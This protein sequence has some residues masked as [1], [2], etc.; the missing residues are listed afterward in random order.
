MKHA[1]ASVPCA[2]KNLPNRWKTVLDCCPL[3]EMMF[4]PQGGSLHIFGAGAAFNNRGQKATVLSLTTIENGTN[5]HDR[6]G[7]GIISP[8]VIDQVRP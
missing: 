3:I 1:G 7:W 2:R 4:H 6:V 8:L 5:R